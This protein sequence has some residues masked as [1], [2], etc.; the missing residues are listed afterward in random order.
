MSMSIGRSRVRRRF[1][2]PHIASSDFLY[3]KELYREAFEGKSE[4]ALA[5]ADDESRSLSSRLSE[6]ERRKLVKMSVN[7]AGKIG[8]KKNIY[9]LGKL[10]EVGREIENRKSLTVLEIGV[11]GGTAQ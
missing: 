3:L 2:T 10:G 4:K 11:H 6:A 9:K 1:K 5:K 7:V 8:V